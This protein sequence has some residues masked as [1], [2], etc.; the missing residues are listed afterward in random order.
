MHLAKLKCKNFKPTDKMYRK[1]DGG[2]L[3]LK[4]TPQGGM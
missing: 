3:Y 1:S 4:V 2:N